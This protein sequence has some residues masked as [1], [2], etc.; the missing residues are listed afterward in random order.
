MKSKIINMVDRLKDAED[1]KLEAL[2][3]S[4]PIEDDGFSD[5]VVA[6]VRRKVWVRRLALPTAFVVGLSI[7][8]KPLLQFAELLPTLVGIIPANLGSVTDLPLDNLPQASTVILGAM[9]VMGMLM[10]G[11][12]LEE[13]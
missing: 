2:F 7:A 9:L 13:A 4:D 6:R 8:V 10:V 12:M 1:L 5:R 11:R 3:G